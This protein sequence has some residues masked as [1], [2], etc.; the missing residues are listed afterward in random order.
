LN[1]SSTSS[2]I[3]ATRPELIATQDIQ[4]GAATN[5]QKNVP[6]RLTVAALVP[7]ALLDAEEAK[8]K[9]GGGA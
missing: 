3:S 4:F 8:K 9:Q 7:R 5:P 6:L 1:R 2:P